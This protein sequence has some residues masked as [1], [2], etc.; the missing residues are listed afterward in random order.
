MAETEERQTSLNLELEHLTTLRDETV[1]L[2]AWQD[3]MNQLFTQ[4][5]EELD[6]VDCDRK[7]LYS[8]PKDERT[9]ILKRR[10][11]IVRALVEKVTVYADGRVEITGAL[12]GSEAAQF[13]LRYSA[14][15][16]AGC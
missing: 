13:E 4:V 12:D 10:R 6:W 9:G 2:E 8:L 1:Q 7:K 11:E 15:S 16:S 5:R 14:G 3:Y